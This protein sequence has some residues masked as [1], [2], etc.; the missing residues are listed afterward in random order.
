MKSKTSSLTPAQVESTLKQGTRAMPGGCTT[1]CGAGLSDA[2]KTMGLLGGTTPP[3]SGNLLLNPGFEE[4][5]VSWTSDH[6]DT[7]ETG[8]NARTG[9]RFAGLNGWGQA[10]SYKLDQAFR[11]PVHGVRRVAVLLP[12]GA[13]GRNHASSAYDTLKVQVISGGTTTTLATYSNL[14]ESAGY[15]Q[16]QL[17]LSAYKGKSVTLRF[18][19][20]ED[21]SLSTY[22]FLDDTAVTT[23]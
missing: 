14:N 12:E 20:V 2:T 9:S 13:V 1:G 7:F 8:T 16:K 17:D 11:R 18:L 5:A 3:P 4:G 22:F 21:S 6:A 19:G 15:V 10:T 23:S